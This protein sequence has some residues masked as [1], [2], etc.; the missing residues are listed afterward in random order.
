MRKNLELLAQTICEYVWK[1]KF[2]W[3]MPNG[4]ENRIR[5]LRNGHWYWISRAVLQRYGRVL[6]SSG[7]AVYNVLASYANAKSQ[8]C[9]PTQQA[10][11][12]RTGLCR[13]T[14]NRKI[15]IL[16][17]LGLISVKRQKRHCIYFLLKPNVILNHTRCDGRITKDVILCHTNNN[18]KIKLYNKN[19]GTGGFNNLK[20]L[21]R[22]LKRYDQKGY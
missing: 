4:R 10:I 15:V 9:F 3:F 12:D 5:N 14:V 7:L 18:K 19:N 11:A 8:T 6:K 17:K 13:E 20:P 1:K 16:K 2:Y 21:R 22:L